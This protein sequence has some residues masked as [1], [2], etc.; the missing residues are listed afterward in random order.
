MDFSGLSQANDIFFKTDDEVAAPGRT[1]QCTELMAELKY[2]CEWKHDVTDF[3]IKWFTKSNLCI[4]KP[5]H[6]RNPGS[7]LNGYKLEN[8]RSNAANPVY[9]AYFMSR[10]EVLIG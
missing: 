10:D 8:S 2:E 9:P 5:S 3:T 6:G 1:L 7:V 4:D